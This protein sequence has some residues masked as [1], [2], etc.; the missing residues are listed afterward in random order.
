M[1]KASTTT[2]PAIRSLNDEYLDGR[3]APDDYCDPNGVCGTTVLARAGVE[4]GTMT[5]TG[6]TTAGIGNHLCGRVNTVYVDE[7]S[8]CVIAQLTKAH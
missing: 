7:I 2:T 3:A 8:A 5:V 6:F 4:Y 1:R